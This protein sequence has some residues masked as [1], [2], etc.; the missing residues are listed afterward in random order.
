MLSETDFK[1]L[2]DSF[3]KEFPGTSTYG[4]MRIGR[5]WREVHG[6]TGLQLLELLGYLAGK[7]RVLPTVEEFCQGISSCRERWRAADRR[8]ENREVEVWINRIPTEEKRQIAR[9]IMARIEG[10]VSDD[11][12]R[13]FCADLELACESTRRR[14]GE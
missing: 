8:Q 2:M 1:K 9:T 13:T 10:K 11:A 14:V 5:I 6:L 3:V 7:Y 12:W 4:P